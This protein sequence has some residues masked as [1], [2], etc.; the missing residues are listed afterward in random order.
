[1]TGN[2]IPTSST[3]GDYFYFGCTIAVILGVLIYS[4]HPMIV[5]AII[6]ACSFA[7]L[8]SGDLGFFPGFMHRTMDHYHASIRTGRLLFARLSALVKKAIRGTNRKVPSAL[9]DRRTAPA[10]TPCSTQAGKVR[11]CIW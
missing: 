8:F 11:H 1:M 10:D 2:G 6:S 5:F 4:T 3:L 7:M 9:G